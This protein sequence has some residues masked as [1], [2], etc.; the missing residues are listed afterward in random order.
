MANFFRIWSLVP[1][2]AQKLNSKAWQWYDLL[3]PFVLV[4]R[5][6]TFPDLA[7]RSIPDLSALKICS[8][9]FKMSIDSNSSFKSLKNLSMATSLFILDLTWSRLS[10]FHKDISGCHFLKPHYHFQ[11][12]PFVGWNLDGW[13][14]FLTIAHAKVL[15]TV[16]VS[17]WLHFV[18]NLQ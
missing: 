10:G 17:G 3:V 5:T 18:I 1:R 2:L 4:I 11:L 8:G 12:R 7:F 13:L 16:T 14:L 15:I 9:L 6:I